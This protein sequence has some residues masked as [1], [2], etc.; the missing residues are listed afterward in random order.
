M[1]T[2]WAKPHHLHLHSDWLGTYAWAL[3]R[4]HNEQY[5][6]SCGWESAVLSDTGS[7]HFVETKGDNPKL[8]NQ[9]THP[10]H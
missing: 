10:L 4:L 1:K 3:S 6:A 9:I 8:K 2:A 7:Q 5:I